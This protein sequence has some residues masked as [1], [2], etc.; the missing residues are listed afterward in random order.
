MRPGAARSLRSRLSWAATLVVAAWAVAL[1]VGAYLLLGAALE[2]EADGALRAR[3]QA[4]AAT[5][6]V[7]AGGAVD[8]AEGADDSALDVGTWIFGPGGTAVE[9]PSGSTAALD[10]RAARLAGTAAAAPQEEAVADAGLV[11]PTRLLA[12]AVP[13]GPGGAGDG[14]PAVVVTSTSLA[15]YEQLR[16]LALVGSAVAALA[17]VLVVHL[18]LRVTVQ[19]AL[20]PV[21]DMTE[22]AGRWSADDVTRRF[23][24][25]PRPAELAALA[26][27]LDGVLDRLGA[28]LRHEQTFTAEVSHEL[29]T[30]LA[31]VRAQVDWLRA[32][33][34][35]PGEVDEGLRAVDDAAADLEV[36]LATLL[37]TARAAGTTAAPGRT[38]VGPV[39]RELA[40]DH[41][42]EG[43]DVA[44]RVLPSGPGASDDPVAGV[45]AAVLRRLLSPLVDNAVRH[46]ASA[47][48][49]SA[50]ATASGVVVAVDDDG[51]GIP[52][53]LREAVFAPGARGTPDDGHDGAGLGLALARRLARAAGGDVVAEDPPGGHLRVRLPAG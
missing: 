6:T 17:L 42:R 33:P 46:A 9:S 36:T 49:L 12:L 32:H 13:A 8:V 2:S 28:V 35:T 30:P 26:G 38:P 16:D 5:V 51:A 21:Q 41:G 40:D 23:G 31:R 39:L 48:V 53:H 27:V 15:P 45:D 24:P 14:G 37:D 25:A 19:R 22:Q 29:R 11:D 34:R 44:V 52:S 50:A 1:A 7:G 18:V 3:A 20:R 47:V 4:V 10:A 43:A